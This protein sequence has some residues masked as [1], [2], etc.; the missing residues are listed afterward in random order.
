MM[1]NQYIQPAVKTQA[2]ATENVMAGS[3][4]SLNDKRPKSDVQDESTT[5]LNSFAKRNN[6]WE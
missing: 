1:K 5:N 6:I 2:I 4:P 3:D